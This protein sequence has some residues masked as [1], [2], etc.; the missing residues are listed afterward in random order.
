MKYNESAR[1]RSNPNQN[2][3]LSNRNNSFLSKNNAKYDRSITTFSNQGRLLQVEYGIEASNQGHSVVCLQLDWNPTD[4]S[5]HSQIQSFSA[6][7]VA[8]VVPT[9][10]TTNTNT[11]NDENSEITNNSQDMEVSLTVKAQKIHRIDDHCLLLTTGLIGDG[12]AL[13]Q[14]TRLSCQKMRLMYGETPTLSEIAHHVSEIQHELTRTSGARPFGV[15]ATIFGVDPYSFYEDDSNEMEDDSNEMQV[16][17]TLIGKTR[18]FQSEPGG[19]LEE[20]YACAAGKNRK[21]Y[22]KKLMEVRQS[23]LQMADTY[24]A[25]MFDEKEDDINSQSTNQIHSKI[26]GD[27]V[28][29]VGEVLFDSNEDKNKNEKVKLIDLWVIESDRHMERRGGARIRC[30]KN[31]SR[32]DLKSLQAIFSSLT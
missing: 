31:V 25:Q 24:A 19:I 27:M 15:T 16:D 14:S 11:N 30:A 26:L 10:S 20:F 29:G 8:L 28:K 23:L 12:R 4:T 7:C 1:L 21:N 9:P 17:D 32:D 18:L 5:P 22:E 6:V 3:P 2:N 13:A